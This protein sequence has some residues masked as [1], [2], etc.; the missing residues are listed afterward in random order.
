VAGNVRW[1][2]PAFI[3][4]AALAY[5]KYRQR[6]LRQLVDNFRRYS[7]PDA[8]LYDAISAPAFSGLFAQIAR[9]LV[10]WAPRARVL[11][12]GSGPGRLAVKLAQLGPEIQV[13]GIDIVPEMVTLATA[14]AR[15]A[16]LATRVDFRLADVMALPFADGSFDV[17]V[18][19]FSLHHWPNPATGLA[20]VYRVLRPGGFAQ[21]YDIADWIRRFETGGPSS[22]ELFE[23]SPFGGRGTVTKMVTTR[24][25]PI[26]IVYRAELKR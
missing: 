20:E 19:T 14:H 21:I 7:M 24:L 4:G 13:T 25:G 12:V 1:L 5:A 3:G 2:I 8:T 23:R 6:E 16:S 10:A 15:Q 26:P 11:E 18:S 9:D 22:A 17:V